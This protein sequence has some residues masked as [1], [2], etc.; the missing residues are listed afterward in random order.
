MLE[1]VLNREVKLLLLDHMLLE[2]VKQLLQALLEQTQLLQVLQAIL[3]L[4]TLKVRLN[5]R[6]QQQ[7]ANI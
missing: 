1:T 7:E 2:V 5:L 6:L 3:H 4:Q